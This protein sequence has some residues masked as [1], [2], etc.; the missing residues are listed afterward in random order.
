M[1]EVHR[2]KVFEKLG[3]DSAAEL[4]TTLADMRAA[5]I[6]LEGAAVATD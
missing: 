3:V 4:A 2:S 6:A 1:V 5:G